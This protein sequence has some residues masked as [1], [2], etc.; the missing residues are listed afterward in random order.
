MCSLMLA[1]Y[2]RALWK[3]VTFKYSTAFTTHQ[4]SQFESDSTCRDALST[5]Q[6]TIL[7]SFVPLFCLARWK[8]IITMA[9]NW[10]DCLHL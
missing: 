1:D 9:R 3:I 4:S 2:L 7:V 10:A 8:D 6:C 5:H